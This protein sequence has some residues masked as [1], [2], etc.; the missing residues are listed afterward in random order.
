M[1]PFVYAGK[2]V[3]EFPIQEQFETDTH[4]LYEIF[5]FLSGDVKHLIEGN[6][7]NLK[8]DDIIIIKKCE[9]HKLLIGKSIPFCRY[10]VHFNSKAILGNP[11]HLFEKLECK[12][13][14]KFNKIIAT[15]LQKSTWL[16]FINKMIQAITIE[17]KRIYLSVIFYEIC[18]NLNLESAND[19]DKI[20]RY[21]NLNL[22]NI[23]SLSEIC[24]HFYISKT[25]L[26]K[27]F[28]KIIGTTVWDYIIT[29]RL[30]IAK[31]M[32][33]E[34]HNPNWVAQKCG[35]N[36]YSAFYRAYKKQFNSSPKENYIKKQ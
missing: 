4:E 6:I 21:I 35:Y 28:K 18:Q 36:E 10:V 11:S 15:E 26:N 19:G 34:G 3:T 23:Q 7:Y 1:E 8:P 27:H 16:Y 17:E 25:Y 9:T 5:C 32:L 20:I 24:K 12:P 2:V 31:D 30:I 14:G 33:N 13:L 29:K 22:M